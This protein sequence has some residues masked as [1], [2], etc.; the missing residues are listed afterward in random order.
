M[1]LGGDVLLRSSSLDASLSKLLPRLC[2]CVCFCF[3]FKNTY[4][5]PALS[6]SKVHLGMSCR[7]LPSRPPP[8]RSP[9]N[10]LGCCTIDTFVWGQKEI[11][12]FNAGPKP[13]H[14]QHIERRWEKGKF[15][16]CS[17]QLLY[18][19]ICVCGVDWNTTYLT[20]SG[21]PSYKWYIHT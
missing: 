16:D 9:I 3:K 6:T 21:T 4:F 11:D 20:Y 12:L 18:I 5:S 2:V 19:C 10:N 13:H 8:L 15:S 14:L 7:P 1:L 17:K